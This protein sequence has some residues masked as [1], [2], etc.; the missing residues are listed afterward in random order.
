MFDYE[1]E[2]E[3][4]AAPLR[5]VNQ[6]GEA[7]QLSALTSLTAELQDLMSE[8]QTVPA[9]QWQSTPEGNFLLPVST[10]FKKNAFCMHNQ[11]HYAAAKHA[12]AQMHC[13]KELLMT[14]IETI[15][16]GFVNNGLR[17]IMHMI[18]HTQCVSLSR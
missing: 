6:T 3:N 11:Y 13:L 2:A 17:R 5:K 4:P 1:G 7:D 18:A 8:L 9:A 14:Q 15:G 16:L 12:F 10:S